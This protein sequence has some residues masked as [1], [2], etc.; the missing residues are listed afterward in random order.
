MNAKGSEV[1]TAEQLHAPVVDCIW[2]LQ[3]DN[4]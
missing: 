2:D 4:T 1:N 3:T